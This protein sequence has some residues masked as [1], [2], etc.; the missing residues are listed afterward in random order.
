L[1]AQLQ[2]LFGEKV[3]TFVVR[4]PPPT[5]EVIGTHVTEVRIEGSKLTNA[6]T[7]T[8]SDVVGTT[9]KKCPPPIVGTA[10]LQMYS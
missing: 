7:L 4:C 9:P 1:D 5:S 3:F 2:R 6:L 10:L 8:A